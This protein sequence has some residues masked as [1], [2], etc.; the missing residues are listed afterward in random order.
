MGETYS[1]SPY[2]GCFPNARLSTKWNVQAQQKS[3]SILTFILT[4][5]F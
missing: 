3:E 1:D 4:L 2:L 5:E